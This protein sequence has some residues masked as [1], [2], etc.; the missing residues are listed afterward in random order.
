MKVIYLEDSLT[1]LLPEA[2]TCPMV[3]S[4]PVAHNNYDSFKAS[5][6]KSVAMAKVGFGKI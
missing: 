1:R 2:N 6:D 4:I 3:L 5:M